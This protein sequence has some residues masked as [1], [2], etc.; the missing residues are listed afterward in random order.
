MYI[1]RERAAAHYL[2]SE[3]ERLSSAS[4]A[5]S[6]PRSLAYLLGGLGFQGF[7]VSTPR[8]FRGLEFPHLGI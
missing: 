1:Y 3:M 4:A 5:S 2:R 8:G 7:G 6:R